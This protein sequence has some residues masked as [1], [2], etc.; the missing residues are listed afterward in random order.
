VVQCLR[1]RG[2]RTSPVARRIGGVGLG[3]EGRAERAAVD[4]HAPRLRRLC[5]ASGI[6]APLRDRA[7]LPGAGPAGQADAGDASLRAAAARLLATGPPPRRRLA[8]TARAPGPSPRTDREAADA[9][10]GRRR[11]CGDLRGAALDGRHVSRWHA[12]LPAPPAER[13]QLLRPLHREELLAQ[14]PRRLLSPPPP[15]GLHTGERRVG[16]AAGG[17]QL[18]DCAPGCVAALPGGGLAVVPGDAGPGDRTG[19]G[20]HASSGR[21]LHVPPVDRPEHHAGLGCRGSPGRTPLRTNRPGRGRHRRAGRAWR[22][23]AA[24]ADLLAQHDL[25]L[26]ARRRGH[27]GELPGLS[28]PRKRTAGGR[29]PRRSVGSLRRSGAPEAAVG[30]PADRPGQHTRRTGRPRSGGSSLPGGVALRSRQRASAHQPGKGAERR[31]GARQGHPESPSRAAPGSRWRAG[32]DPRT[33]RA[34]AREAGRCGRG[35]AALPR[36]NRAEAGS[37]RGPRQPRRSAGPHRAP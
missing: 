26:S 29:A 34:G 8:P 32:P 5:R 9:A 11:E 14:R 1:R 17:R 10:G 6:A 33:A 19:S 30:R 35:H 15:F 18:R 28:R 22:L 37:R 24:P 25:S 20:G 4:A 12:P 23:R 2:V 7:R 21:S 13:A 27:R 16:P 31:R 3:A 36:G